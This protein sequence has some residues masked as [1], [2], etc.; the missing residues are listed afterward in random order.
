MQLNPDVETLLAGYPYN[1]D[2]FS[3]SHHLN[4]EIQMHVLSAV[5]VHG[6]TSAT[7]NDPVKSFSDLPS[8]ELDCEGPPSALDDSEGLVL[9]HLDFHKLNAELINALSS[10]ERSFTSSCTWDEWQVDPHI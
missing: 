3:E 1:D 10:L 5:D 9:V 4:N 8:L 7:D 2:G 6:V